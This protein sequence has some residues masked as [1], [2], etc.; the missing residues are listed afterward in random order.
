MSRRGPLVNNDRRIV[1]VAL[2]ALMSDNRIP[3][4]AFRLWHCLYH[5]RDHETGDCYPGQRRIAKL[6]GCQLNSLEPWTKALEENKWVEVRRSPLGGR[7]DYVLLDGEG[8]QLPLWKS[9][10]GVM[11]NHHT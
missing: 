6:I 7:F 1:A 11:E 9:I 10:T 4:G 3:H 5:H 2:S 8:K